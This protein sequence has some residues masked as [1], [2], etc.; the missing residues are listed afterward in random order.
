MTREE[1]R[2]YVMSI[3][4]GLYSGSDFSDEMENMIDIVLYLNEQG[5]LDEM[6]PEVEGSRRTIHMLGLVIMHNRRKMPRIKDV[7]RF[8]AHVRERIKK[9]YPEYAKLGVVFTAGIVSDEIFEII[10]NEENDLQK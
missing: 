9:I 3:T 6:M 1:A 2:E 7:G 8:V 5:K 10:R 4:F